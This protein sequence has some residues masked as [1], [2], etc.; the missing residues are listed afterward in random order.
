MIKAMKERMQ[1]NHMITTNEL[2]ILNNIEQHE[3][4]IHIAN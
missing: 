2:K 3:P 1:P 4:T